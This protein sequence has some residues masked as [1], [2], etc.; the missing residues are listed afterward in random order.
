MSRIENNNFQLNFDVFDLH[1][2]VQ[3]VVE[4]LDF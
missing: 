3:E 4:I 1:S 2:T